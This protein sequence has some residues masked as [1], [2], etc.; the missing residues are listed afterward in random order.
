MTA[1]A[2]S[3]TPDLTGYAGSSL[4]ANSGYIFA[5]RPTEIFPSNRRR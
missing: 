2:P 3:R 4:V 1:H 5:T